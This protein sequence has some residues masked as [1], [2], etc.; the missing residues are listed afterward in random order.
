MT[1]ATRARTIV[2]GGVAL[3]LVARAAALWVAPAFGYVP[4]HL[5]NMA[6]STWART[7]GAP[8]IYDMQPELVPLLQAATDP[9]SGRPVTYLTFAPHACNYPPF[10]AW[11]FWVKGALWHALDTDVRT[12]PTPPALRALLGSST[13]ELRT[14]NTRL[15]R[16][17]DALPSFVFDL[18]LALGVVGLV[19]LLRGP[20]DATVAGAIGFAL[21]FAAPVVFLDAALW[22]QSDS[23][24]GTMLVWCL[25]WWLRGRYGAAG[26]LYGVA[27]VTK[28]QAILLAPVLAFAVAAL[29]YGPDGS[30]R[31][32]ARSLRAVPAALVTVAAIAAPFMLH[33]ARSGAGAWRWVARSYVGTI[34]AEEYALTTLNAFNLW[35]IDLLAQRPWTRGADWWRLLDSTMPVLGPSKDAIGAMLLVMSIVLAAALCASRLGWTATSVVTFGFVVLLS[36]FLLPTRVHERYVF[37]ALP[38]LTALAAHQ[39]AWRVPWLG[40]TLVGTAEMLSHLWVAPTL[41]SFAVSGAAAVA[42]LGTLLWTYGVLLWPPVEEGA[43]TGAAAPSPPAGGAEMKNLGR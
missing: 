18:L 30:W 13:L 1:T 3:G 10:S 2:L 35:W 6:W 37:Y 5:D 22:G 31:R 29:R 40:L 42:A 32:A 9:A 20:R 25:V 4:D 17:V 23:W 27:L 36:A 33:D 8:A 11:V 43:E 19:R 21:L 34:G 39:R 16:S 41:P 26:A 14:V 7:R 12:I 15:A 24:I 38:F 28:P